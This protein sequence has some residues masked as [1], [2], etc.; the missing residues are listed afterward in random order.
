MK[1]IV[2]IPLLI[3]GQYL[4]SQPKKSADFILFK[5]HHKTIG[6]YYAGNNIAFTTIQGNYLEAMITE[7]KHDSIFLRQFIVQQVPTNFGVYVLDTV[8]SYR[9][10]YSYKDI[11]AIAEQVENS[12]LLQVRPA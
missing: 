3:I 6:S 8:A 10:Q 5:Q 11:K 1:I 2:L 4:F 12:I 9:Y 7:I